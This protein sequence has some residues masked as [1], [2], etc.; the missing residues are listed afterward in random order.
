MRPPEFKNAIVEVSSLT[1]RDPARMGADV[2]GFMALPMIVLAIACVNAANLLLARATQ[3]SG[4]WLVRL[5]IGATR[6]RLIRQLLV[7]SLLLAVAGATLGAVLCYWT[8]ALLPRPDSPIP[9]VVDGQVLTFTM[10]VACA[11][12]LVFGLGPALSVTRPAAARSP[13]APA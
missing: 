4:D 5:A 9:F 2:L 3:R 7:E 11:T 8:L 13:K 6:W 1:M 12:A 10:A